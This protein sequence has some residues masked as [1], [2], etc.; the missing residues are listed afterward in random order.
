MVSAGKQ[1]GL[2]DVD[3]KA[4]EAERQ[5]RQ[6]QGSDI[7]KIPPQPPINNNNGDGEMEDGGEDE[8]GSRVGTNNS[9][10]SFLSVNSDSRIERKGDGGDPSGGLGQG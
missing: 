7:H 3:L 2:G 8:N 9:S 4:A 1:F 10:G 5:K 6:N